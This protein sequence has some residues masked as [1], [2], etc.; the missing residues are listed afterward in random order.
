MTVD[1]FYFSLQLLEELLHLLTGETGLRLR[2]NLA[3]RAVLSAP[4]TQSR[5]AIPT[6]PTKAV[7]KHDFWP[8]LWQS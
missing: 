4:S 2:R 7:P 8:N 3:V 5:L 1:E 6:V